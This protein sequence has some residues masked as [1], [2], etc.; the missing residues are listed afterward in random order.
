M[1]LT[2]DETLRSILIV[3]T[4][5]EWEV[6]LKAS[7]RNPTELRNLLNSFLKGKQESFIREDRDLVIATIKEAPVPML[8]RIKRELGLDR[9]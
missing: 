4:E 8:D 1:E 2:T 6:M 7:K 3:F 5:P 9:R